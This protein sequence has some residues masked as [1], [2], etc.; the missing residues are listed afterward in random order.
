M[1]VRLIKAKKTEKR[2]EKNIQVSPSRLTA[3]E[4]LRRVE[5]EVCYVGNS[6]WI[7]R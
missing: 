6:G 2:G 3:F 4:I 5:E 1:K 7:F